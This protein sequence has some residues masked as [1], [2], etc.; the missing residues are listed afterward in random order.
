LPLILDAHGQ[1]A[2]EAPS[3]IDYVLSNFAPDN[4]ILRRVPHLKLAASN[5]RGGDHFKIGEWHEVSDF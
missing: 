4:P 2:L 3:R 5:L 1:R